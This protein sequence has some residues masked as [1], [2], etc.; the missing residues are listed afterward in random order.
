MPRSRVILDVDRHPEIRII[1]IIQIVKQPLKADRKM[2]HSQAAKAESRDK[3]MRI[4]SRALRENGIAALGVNEL[5][6]AAGMTHGGFYGHFASRDAL[7]DAALERALAAGAKDAVLPGEP[8]PDARSAPSLRHYVRAYLSRAHRDNPGTGCAMAA[9]AGDLSRAPKRLRTRFTHALRAFH[10]GL[11]GL[12][13][14]DAARRQSLAAVSTMI[15]ALILSRAVDDE[16]LS[17]EILLSAKQAVIALG[18]G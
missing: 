3:I 11:A 4:A 7:I 8:A 18:E 2:G 15:G 13:G 1:P 17:D 6:R 16:A 14:G 9:L 5:M 10:N 12:I